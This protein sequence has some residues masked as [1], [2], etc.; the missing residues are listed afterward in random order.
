MA[1]VHATLKVT[2]LPARVHRTFAVVVAVNFSLH[3]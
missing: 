2:V 3:V 1:R